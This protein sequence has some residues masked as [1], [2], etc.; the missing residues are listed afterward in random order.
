MFIDT[1]LHLDSPVYQDLDKIIFDAK[2]QNVNKFI[3]IGTSFKEF[4]VIKEIS[5]RSEVFASYGVYP[6]YDN[7]YSNAF[8][9]NQIENYIKD[10]KAVAVGE[11]GFDQPFTEQERN[12]I[13][14][15]E[16]FRMQIE[17][18]I[19]NKL[20]LVVHTR[21]SDSQT[22]SVLKDYKNSTLKG[23]IHCFVSDFEF[24]KKILDLG[25][26]VSFNGIITYK[27]GVNILETIEKIPLDRILLETD[28]PHLTPQNY[29]KEINEPK[30]IP[31]IAE[32][33]AEVKKLSIEEIEEAT[34]NNSLILF[35]KIPHNG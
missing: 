16:I 5:K 22:Y 2:L 31:L 12:L 25:F 18:A 28:A 35:D 23:V 24:A 10:K 14:Q 33:I 7:E 3:T 19:K 21:N 20:P 27:S 15:E 26:Y 34:L 17:L 29:R 1:H 13:E 4:E 8:L 9:I 11:C 32:K 6:T 30:F